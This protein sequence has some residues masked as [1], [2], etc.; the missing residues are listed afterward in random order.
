MKPFFD[1]DPDDIITTATKQLLSAKLIEEINIGS[2][3]IDGK[4]DKLV[5]NDN[6]VLKANKTTLLYLNYLIHDYEYISAMATVSYQLINDE[7]KNKNIYFPDQ[8]AFYA[9][10]TLS[11][12]ISCKDILMNN[13]NFYKN[14][15]KKNLLDAFESLFVQKRRNFKKFPW[16]DAINSSIN[17][18]KKE[19]NLYSNLSP[20][21]KRMME[22]KTK[23]V[24][25]MKDKYGFYFEEEE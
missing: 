1:E 4:W 9:Q 2:R 22:L 18:L 25:E 10:N 12:L 5:L 3:A 20:I 6:A 19:E 8:P 15:K 16:L 7:N 21:R 13:L 17:Y 14:Y 23:T 24:D 11:F